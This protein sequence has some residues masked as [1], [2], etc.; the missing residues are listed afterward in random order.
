MNKFL[1]VLFI[2]AMTGCIIFQ[3]FFPTYMGSHSGYGISVGW[4]REIG[5]WNVAVLVILIAINL[6][7]DWFYLRAI[8]MALIIG[9]FGNWN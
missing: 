7:Y 3:L 2:F 5:I 8:L 4:Q 6:K 9:G 1:R